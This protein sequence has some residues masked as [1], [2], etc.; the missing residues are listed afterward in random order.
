MELNMKFYAVMHNLTAN[1]AKQLV[2]TDNQD[3]YRQVFAT[4]AKATKYANNLKN[5]LLALVKEK[6][7]EYA[8]ENTVDSEQLKVSPRKLIENSNVGIHVTSFT[9]NGKE[10]IAEALSGNCLREYYSYDD[11][12]GTYDHHECAVFFFDTIE[13]DTRH[14]QAIG[15]PTYTE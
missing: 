10:E 9:L 1:T 7:D 2:F 15:D 3:V 6:Q 8:E 11:E 14:N 5:A 4:K 13:S 12:C